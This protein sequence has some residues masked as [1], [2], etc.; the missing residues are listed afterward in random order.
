V[1]T[2]VTSSAIPYLKILYPQ[3]GPTTTPGPRAPPPFKS[4]AGLGRW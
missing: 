1:D 3:T 2:V 4:G